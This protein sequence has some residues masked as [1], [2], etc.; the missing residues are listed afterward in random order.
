MT[1]T[2]I[3]TKHEWCGMTEDKSN[4]EG[5]MER[6]TTGEDRVRMIARQLSEPRTANWIASEAGWSHEPTKRVL[7]RLVDDGVLH[8]DDSGTHT[9]YYPDY[10]R[11]AMQEAMR[12]RDSGHTVEELTDRLADMKAQIRDWEDEFGV[13]SPNQLR[14]TLAEESLDADEEDR[15]REIAR[16]WEHLQRRIKIVGFAIREWDFLAPTTEPAEA[17]S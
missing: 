16:E 15:R 17:S 7:E 4:S 6:Q 10:R 13:E 11:Q 8:R 5:L 2:Y 14:G 9:T 3:K 12:L 1:S